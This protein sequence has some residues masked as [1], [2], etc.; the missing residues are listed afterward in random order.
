MKNHEFNTIKTADGSEMELYFAF[1]DGQGPFPAIIVLQEAFGVTHHI[2]TV[3]ERFCKEGY[4]VVSPDLYHRTALRLEI[5]YEDFMPAMPHMQALTKEGLTVDLQAAYDF[6]QQQEKVVKGKTGSVGFCLGGRVSFLANAI[7]PLSAAI[8]YYGGG[9]E[10]LADEAKNLHGTHLFYWG[11]L[12]KH[13]SQDK[14]ETIINAVKEAGKDY[15]NVMFS[16]ADH[17]FNCDERESFHPLASKEAWA[18]TLSFF[19]NRLK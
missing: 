5:S 11:G 4:A 3:A 18:H 14:I 13:I 19:E 16:Y 6:L 2:R 1:P 8:S 9:L 17:G 7:L 12:D 15:A 10:Q